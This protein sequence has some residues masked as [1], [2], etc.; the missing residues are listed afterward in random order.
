MKSTIYKISTGNKPEYD[1]GHGNKGLLIA[2]DHDD[3]MNNN[4]TLQGL[5]KA[6]KF[7]IDQD[8]KI[9][10]TTSNNTLD[11]NSII[12]NG[13]YNTIILIGIAPDQTGFGL[14]AKKYFYYNL[15]NFSLLLTDSLQA[16][17]NDKSKKM[18]FWN[19]LQEKFLLKN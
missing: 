19:N 6:I 18:S 13:S 7:D 3:M 12:A 5:V 14:Q 17:N 1:R 16:M 9:V 15:Q 11:L 8:V 10:T 4:P 2:L